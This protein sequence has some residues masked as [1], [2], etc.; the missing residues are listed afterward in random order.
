M[1]LTRCPECQTAFRVTP[2]Q[3]QARSGKVRCG[4]CHGVFNALAHLIDTVPDIAPEKNRESRPEPEVAAAPPPP[5]NSQTDRPELAAL[6]PAEAPVELPAEA[7]PELTEAP[8]IGAA[9]EGVSADSGDYPWEEPHIAEVTP[10]AA[11]AALEEI[12]ADAPFIPADP[13]LPRDTTAIPGYSKWAETPLAAGSALISEPGRRPRWPFVLASVMLSGLLVGQ[14]AHRFRGDLA[15]TSPTLA[16]AFAAMGWDIPLQR[17]AELITID[18]S[19]LQSDAARNLLILQATLKNRATFTQALPSLELT[20]TD[21]RDGII[22]RRVLGP[23]DY[24]GPAG[25][26]DHP[27]PVPTTFAANG[28]LALRLWIDAR[29][30]V[31]AGYRLYVFYP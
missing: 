31:A 19:D 21:T 5:E 28:E 16:R 22:A 12:T 17:R 9:S 6:P 20:L 1:S 4:H 10:A 7:I 18:A 25:D 13:I 2:E 11:T 23:A 29:D 24:L 30:M 8:A 14:I 15:V 26:K 3:L 27:A